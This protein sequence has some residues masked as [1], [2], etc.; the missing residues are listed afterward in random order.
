MADLLKIT[1]GDLLDERAS[2]F[3]GN[4]VLIDIPQRKRFTYQEFTGQV[5]QLARGFT[6]LGLQKGDHVALWASNSFQWII[7]QFAIAKIGAVLISVDMNYKLEQ[8]D[9]LL[10]QSDS[11]CLVTVEGIKGS[12]NLEMVR[13]LSPGEAHRSHLPELKHIVLIS[14]RPQE[15]MFRWT[16][17]LDMGE[18]VSDHVLK[19]RQH[20]C[21]DE[22]IVT[23][24]YTSGTT[25][26]PKGVMSTH[27]G[28]I[29]T[30]AASSEN[31]KLTE[32]DRLCLSV[33]LSHMF[34]CICVV[35]AAVIRGAGVVIP[36]QT[37][38]PLKI[39]EAIERERCTALYGSPSSFIAIMEHP[40]FR[41]FDLKTLR[42][43]IMGGAQ[44]PMEVMKRVVGDMG[45]REIVVGYGQTEAS[46][47]ITQTRPE[48]RL[49]LRVSTVGRPLP[50]VEVKVIDSNSG[51]EVTRGVSGEICARGFT[52]KGYYKMPAATV[53]AIDPQGWLHTGDVGTMDQEGYLRTSGRLKEMINK[54]GEVIYPTEIEEVLFN[55]PK[56]SNAQVF[57][58]PSKAVGE[59]IAAW[60]KLEEGAIASAEEI[61]QHC[62]KK[63][64]ETHLPRYIKFVEE[65]PMTPLGKIQ[66]FKMREMAIREY[67]LE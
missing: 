48:D 46:S 12:E 32:E 41:R 61:L 16:E 21:H 3:P 53:H 25:G 31:Q 5:N 65:Y 11:K 57:G 47:W 33:P 9:Y 14:D 23:I 10:R 59:E 49:E 64:P 39:L 60:I 36:S 44:C 50:N 42:T 45:A 38:D 54:G 63:L 22:D 15:G 62:R 55:C 58:V 8:L 26:A 56:V 7:T 67:G 27:D 24:L 34:G 2:Q 13:Q 4:E 1:V 66:K 43:G 19:E 37:F 18:G 40:E 28:V 30:T 52:M 17:I 29:N 51:Q 20:A 35:L 6:R